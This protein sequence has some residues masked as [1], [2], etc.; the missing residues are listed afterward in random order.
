AYTND[1]N[2]N[3][4]ISNA[5]KYSLLKRAYYEAM[6]SEFLQKVVRLLALLFNNQILFEYTVDLINQYAK[7]HDYLKDIDT[8]ER[9]LG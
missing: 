4:I 1:T 2:G 9:L 5:E 7:F 6:R 3:R 8:E